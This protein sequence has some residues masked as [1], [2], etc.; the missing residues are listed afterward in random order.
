MDSLTLNFTASVCTLQR[1][2]GLW[3]K[4]SEDRSQRTHLNVNVCQSKYNDL[5][6]SKWPRT[7]AICY[8]WSPWQVFVCSLVRAITW[9]L[10]DRLIVRAALFRIPLHIR[11]RGQVGGE[12]FVLYISN[13]CETTSH[14]SY[15][16]SKTQIVLTIMESL[17]IL[18]STDLFPCLII[19]GMLF[20]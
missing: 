11:T 15:T 9:T 19:A 3:F 13:N 10:Y 1:P 4:L 2:S 20:T 7:S 6:H 8:P 5:I 18:I 17:K 14:I 16:A 12:Q